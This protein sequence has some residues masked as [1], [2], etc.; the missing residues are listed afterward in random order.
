MNSSV[1]GELFSSWRTKKEFITLYNLYWVLRH[2]SIITDEM[3]YSVKSQFLPDSRDVVF[4]I[5]IDI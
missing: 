2:L 5:C 4:S 1:L 3:K